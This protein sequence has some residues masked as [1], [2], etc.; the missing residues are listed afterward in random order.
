MTLEGS[1]HLQTAAT[2]LCHRDN[3][4]EA[5]CSK[6]DIPVIAPRSDHDSTG[7]GRFGLLL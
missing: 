1:L 3:L 4:L 2:L 5:H 6:F 7:L